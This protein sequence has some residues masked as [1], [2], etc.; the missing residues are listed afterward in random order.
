[1]YNTKLV[2]TQRAQPH[3]F[4]ANISA[5]LSVK[6]L[7]DQ[8]NIPDMISC[9]MYIRIEFIPGYMKGEPDQNLKTQ[10]LCHAVFVHKSV[11]FKL[12]NVKYP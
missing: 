3:M 9:P 5:W 12:T 8:G 10:K 7:H 4:M 6:G 11:N 2:R 1:M